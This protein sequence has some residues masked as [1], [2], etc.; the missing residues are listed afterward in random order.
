M[1][2]TQL[3][4]TFTNGNQKPKKQFGWTS[5]ANGGEND[6]HSDVANILEETVPLGPQ[7]ATFIYIQLRLIYDAHVMLLT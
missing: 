5:L 6:D 3:R 2:Q 1:N 4:S 7:R